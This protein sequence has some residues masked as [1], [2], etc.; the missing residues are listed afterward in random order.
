MSAPVTFVKS[1]RK[2]Y[3][4][5]GDVAEYYEMDIWFRV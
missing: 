1:R 2:R 3:E 5:C 4:A